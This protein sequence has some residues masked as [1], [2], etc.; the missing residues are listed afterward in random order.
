MV[1]DAVITP[2]MKSKWDKNEEDSCTLC[3]NNRGT[4]QHIYRRVALS[5]Y[6]K[7]GRH[8]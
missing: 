2:S 4:I 8:G 3:V 7:E 6:S 1:Y 5:N